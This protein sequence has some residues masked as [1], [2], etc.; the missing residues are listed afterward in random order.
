MEN[1]NKQENWNLK[2][3]K[4]RKEESNK[5]EDKVKI[6]TYQAAPEKYYNQAVDHNGDSGDTIPMGEEFKVEYMYM[7]KVKKEEGYDRV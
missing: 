7:D 6:L 3:K 4:N 2:R 5:M 1:S